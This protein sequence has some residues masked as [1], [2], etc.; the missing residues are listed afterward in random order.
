MK[1]IQNEENYTTFSRK[2]ILHSLYARM[3]QL[4]CSRDLDIQTD[5]A[6]EKNSRFVRERFVQFCK[7]EWYSFGQNYAALLEE[8]DIAF[9]VNQTAF[10]NIYYIR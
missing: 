5:T 8:N 7:R 3:I 1:I 9:E 4:L 10:V 2:R 6:S